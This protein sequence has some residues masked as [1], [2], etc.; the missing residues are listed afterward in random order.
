MKTTGIIALFVVAFIVYAC[1]NDKEEML[2]P[3]L[4]AACDTTNVTFSGTIK[5]LLSD[6]CY[7]CHSN[8]NA[9]SFGN[10][11]RLENYNDVN[12]M[13]IRMVNSVSW[14]GY[15][16]MPKNGNKLSDCKIKEILIW[17]QNG[18]PNN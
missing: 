7:A 13:L 5:P 10:N 9:P 4:S 15:E 6:N 8:S 1:Y 14:T 16:N 11:I 2:Y 12:S 17:Q 3:Q 18:A